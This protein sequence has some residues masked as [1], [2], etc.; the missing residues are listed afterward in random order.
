[1]DVNYI[2]WQGVLILLGLA[3]AFVACGL[4]VLKRHDED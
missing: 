4:W 3:A 1:M 2:T